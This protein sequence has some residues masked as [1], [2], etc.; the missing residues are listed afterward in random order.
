MNS[1]SGRDRD[2]EK[3]F[4]GYG[5]VRNI[6]IKVRETREY[7]VLEVMKIDKCES[8]LVI[9]LC[10]I[11]LINVDPYASILILDLFVGQS[12][13]VQHEGGY[14]FAEFDEREDAK[15]AVKVLCF[16]YISS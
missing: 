8:T 4:K 11:I 10:V 7:D 12:S 6:V 3:L 2:I 14:G 9:A 1:C 5:R 15:D 16:C 13:F